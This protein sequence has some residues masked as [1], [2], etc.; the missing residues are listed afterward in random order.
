MKVRTVLVAAL[1]I[2]GA[3][4]FV[5]WRSTRIERETSTPRSADRSSSVAAGTRHESAVESV[6]DGRHAESLRIARRV[7]DLE[8]EVDE[9]RREI[10][11]RRA[12]IDAQL[13]GLRL[14]AGASA[15]SCAIKR[16]QARFLIA[17]RPV[18]GVRLDDLTASDAEGRMTAWRRSDFRGFLVATQPD[19]AQ[20]RLDPPQSGTDDVD[21]GDV[22]LEPSGTIAGIVV[23]E[24]GA[25]V[26]GAAVSLL[27]S[28]LDCGT[29]GEGKTA[30]DG[31]FS[32]GGVGPYRYEVC[33]RVPPPPDSPIEAVGGRVVAVSAGAELRVVARTMSP[34]ALHLLDD[35]TGAPV[36]GT[37]IACELRPAG[38]AYDAGVHEL[39]RGEST[40]RLDLDAPG[41]YDVDVRWSDG[42][43]NLAAHLGAVDLRADRANDVDVRLR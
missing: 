2:F 16:I 15:D 4:A 39:R 8:F 42:K 29:V 14:S 7:H 1:S 36:F 24:D 27:S 19:G 25:P 23:N 33:A 38:A 31:R 22:R 13:I 18:A 6:R 26:E 5:S 43:R 32:I 3:T 21:L 11:R 20:I 37:R 34:V 10:E 17:G 41:C 35:A 28:D 12:G 30:A 40:V 9:Q